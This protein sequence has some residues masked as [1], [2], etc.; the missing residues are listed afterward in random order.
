M[1]LKKVYD[2]GLIDDNTVVWVRGADLHLITS[3]NWYQ[4]NVLDYMLADLE[5]FTW[6]DDNNFYID[7][8]E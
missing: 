3:G 5:C 2:L 8:K 6:Q 1:T 4:D 7:L